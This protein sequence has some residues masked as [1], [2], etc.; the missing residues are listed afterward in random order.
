M[1]GDGRSRL[2]TTWPG[3]LK[4]WRSWGETWRNER[5]LYGIY[6]LWLYKT[7]MGYMNDI[8]L[9]QLLFDI[10]FFLD[11]EHEKKLGYVAK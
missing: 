8:S 9:Y 7:Y 2:G 4:L 11:L 10:R 6:K 5:L 3:A 1:T